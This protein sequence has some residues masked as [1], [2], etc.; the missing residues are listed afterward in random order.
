[1][2]LRQDPARES[3]DYLVVWTQAQATAA[4]K[5][6]TRAAP[7]LMRL[8]LP[9]RGRRR[10]RGRPAS[11]ISVQVVRDRRVETGESFR[12]LGRAFGLHRTTIRRW[13]LEED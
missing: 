13:L 1:M 2:L 10:R 8:Q 9:I 4:A 7:S 11:P 5:A 12:Q 3:G 6:A